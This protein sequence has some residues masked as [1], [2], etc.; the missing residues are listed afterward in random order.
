MSQF[1]TKRILYGLLVLAG[2]IT[3]VFLL[4][5]VLPGDPARMLMGQRADEESLR[6]IQKDL[7]LDQTLSTQFVMYLNDLSPIS[8]HSKEEHYLY[9]DEN[10]YSYST[11]FSFGDNNVLVVKT[12]YLRRSYQT[13]RQVSE[14]LLD[15]LPETAVLATAAI[16]FASFFGVLFGIITSLMKDT[17]VDKSLLFLSVLGMSI[18]LLLFL[19]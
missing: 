4:F 5:N 19:G 3:I 6:V 2:V 11:L 12:P 1:I 15:Y 16:L 18:Q 17:W 8:V 14:I 10:K 9:L 7:G 13:K